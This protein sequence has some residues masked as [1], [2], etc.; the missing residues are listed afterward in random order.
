MALGEGHELALSQL[1]AMAASGDAIELLEVVEPEDADGNLLV[2]V[3]P[4]LR[5]L[6]TA[7]GRP[8][9]QSARALPPQHPGRLPVRH[10]L[11]RRGTPAMGGDAAR[12][13]GDASLPLSGASDRVA[14]GRRDV[15]VRRTPALL[16]REGSAR[17]ARSR[18]RRLAS[19]G[20][21]PAELSAAPMIIPR[22]DTPRSASGPGSGWPSSTRFHLAVATSSAGPTSSIRRGRHERRSLSC[23]RRR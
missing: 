22:V 10:A 20:R 15:R 13:V 23:C 9:T 5:K 17:R 18:R 8:E 6:R 12:P 2:R 7:A 14:S 11:G 1:E 19:A 16:A 21:L 4:A 3:Q